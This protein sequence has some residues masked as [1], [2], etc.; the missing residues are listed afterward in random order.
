MEG[1]KQQWIRESLASLV[2][3]ECMEYSTY[4]VVVEDSAVAQ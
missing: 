3:S 4:E 2:V 1:E